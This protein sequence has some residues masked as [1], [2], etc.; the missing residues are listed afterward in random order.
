MVLSE[1]RQRNGGVGGGGGSAD[2]A[3]DGMLGMEE[4]DFQLVFTGA[5]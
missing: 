2:W 4:G 5:S 1:R 3:E